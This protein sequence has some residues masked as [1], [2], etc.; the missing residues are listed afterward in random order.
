VF[1]VS[2]FYK[3]KKIKTTQGQRDELRKNTR[4]FYPA[5]FQYVMR[6]L[7]ITAI[8]PGYRRTPGAEV[9]GMVIVTGILIALSAGESVAIH[10]A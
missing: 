1:F 9:V 6:W 3:E 7:V 8:V 5:L 2:C 10:Y 4:W